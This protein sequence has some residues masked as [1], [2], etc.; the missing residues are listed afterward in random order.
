MV[1]GFAVGSGDE[2]GLSRA[3]IVR[4]YNLGCGCDRAKV[5]RLFDVRRLWVQ[6]AGKSLEALGSLLDFLVCVSWH[7]DLTEELVELAS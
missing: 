3:G 1:P 7:L 5:V 6:R 2:D 4:R